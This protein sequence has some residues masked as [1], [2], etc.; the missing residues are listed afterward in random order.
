MGQ[1]VWRWGG[2]MVGRSGGKT[3]VCN[4]RPRERTM[5]DIEAAGHDAQKYTTMHAFVC[6]YTCILIHAD[7]H[8]PHPSV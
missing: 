5:G 6:T 7:T 1:P 4:T 2:R 8:I 3:S